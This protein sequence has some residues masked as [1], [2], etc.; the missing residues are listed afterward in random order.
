MQNILYDMVD[1][2]CGFLTSRPATLCTNLNFIFLRD[3]R[4]VQILR[5]SYIVSKSANK[6]PIFSIF[7]VKTVKSFSKVRRLEYTCS[8]M[9]N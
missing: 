8:E 5:S 3:E 2:F 6:N 1:S 4:N 9:L 7:N